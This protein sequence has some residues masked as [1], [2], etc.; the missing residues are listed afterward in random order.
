MGSPS[1]HFTDFEDKQQVFEWK[2]LVSLLAR[3]YIGGQGWGL[4]DG[5]GRW[6]CLGW[7]P[8]CISSAASPIIRATNLMAWC[9]LKGISPNIQTPNRGHPGLGVGMG[10]PLPRGGAQ[11]TAGTLQI[12]MVWRTF[13]SG[14]SRRGTSPTT[15]TLTTYP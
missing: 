5:G 13:P 9:R 11:V 12:G 10:I 4:R 1:G 8:S 14:T 2:E 7:L 15:R 6:A 3:R